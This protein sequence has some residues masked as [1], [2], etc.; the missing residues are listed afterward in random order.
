MIVH[1]VM[2]RLGCIREFGDLDDAYKLVN[3]IIINGSR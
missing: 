1:V 2:D 3:L